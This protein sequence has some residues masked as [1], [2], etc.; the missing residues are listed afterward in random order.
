M[1]DKQEYEVYKTASAWPL[2]VV[3]VTCLSTFAGVLLSG[4]KCVQTGE[5]YVPIFFWFGG[6]LI[7]SILFMILIFHNAV[8]TWQQEEDDN[9]DY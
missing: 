1:S 4:W 6:F 3:F 7:S 2:A 9:E 5:L 8:S